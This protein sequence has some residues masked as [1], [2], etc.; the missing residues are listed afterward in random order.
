[1]TEPIAV[2]DHLLEPLRTLRHDLHTP[3]N[4][5]I[6]LSDLWTDTLSTDPAHAELCADLE[7]MREAAW[8]LHDA[9]SATITETGFAIPVT[10]PPERQ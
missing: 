2:P 6:G 8:K 4:N 9:L 5:I 3:L 10:A 7:R 1:M